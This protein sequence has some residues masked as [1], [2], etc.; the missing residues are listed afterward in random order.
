MNITLKLGIHNS[1]VIYRT[2]P[3][4]MMDIESEEMDLF[5]TILTFPSMDFM[6]TT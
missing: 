4:C 5:E 1:I 6:L 2:T 3:K